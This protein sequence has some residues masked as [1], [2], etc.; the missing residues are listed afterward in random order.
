M[1][2]FVSHLLSYI[3]P[4]IVDRAVSSYNGRITVERAFG[5]KRIVVGGYWQ[6][7]DYETSVMQRCLDDFTTDAPSPVESV[8]LLGIGGG[9]GLPVIEKAYPHADIIGVDIDAVMVEVGRKHFGVGRAPNFRAVIGDAHAYVMGSRR[10]RVFDLIINDAY[11]GCDMPAWASDPS[12]LA[13]IGRLLTGSGRYVC[14]GSYT[15][16]NRKRTDAMIAAI[17]QEFAV[18]SCILYPPNMIIRARK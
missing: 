10:D 6:S 13:K 5:R 11:I 2:H 9:S 14:N 4:Q 1:A 17:R 15:P 16:Q 7:G 18:V 8:L 3:T 12:Y